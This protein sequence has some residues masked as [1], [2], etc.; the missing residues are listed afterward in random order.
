MYGYDHVIT[1]DAC[2]S[3][4]FH[5]FIEYYFT[6]LKLTWFH[7]QLLCFLDYCNSILIGFVKKI[8]TNYKLVKIMARALNLLSINMSHQ[9]CFHYADC[10]SSKEFNLESVL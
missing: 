10:P 3:A 1:V 2:K 7:L 5:I 6:C 9:Y 8:C 4:Q